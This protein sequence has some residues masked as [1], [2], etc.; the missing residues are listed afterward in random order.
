MGRFWRKEWRGAVA[1]WKG[2][3]E[4]DLEPTNAV[5]RTS[6]KADRQL[7]IGFG[8]AVRPL[9]TTRAGVTTNPVKCDRVELHHVR[10]EGTESLDSSGV[11][12]RS[13]GGGDGVRSEE[14]VGEDKDTRGAMRAGVGEMELVEAETD[15]HELAQVV[16]A[17]SQGRS[18]VHHRERLRIEE[19][20]ARPSRARVRGRRRVT[21]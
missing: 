13:F 15:R 19:A 10:E 2:Q 1:R 4:V 17:E 3:L 8:D 20:G 5:G 21:D 7:G 14:T 16:R 18:Q 9:V 12:N 6:R 11:G